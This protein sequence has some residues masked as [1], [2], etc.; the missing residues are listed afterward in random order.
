MAKKGWTQEQ[1][2]T[3][4]KAVH[5]D[6]YDYMPTIFISSREDINYICP[7]HG[8]VTQQAQR[9]ASGAGCL[10]CNHDSVGKRTVM[11]LE[12][13]LAKIPEE[14]KAKH[15]YSRVIYKGKNY[16][17]EIG[18]LVHGTY[19]W[20]N[21]QKHRK[22][23]GCPI[24]ARES[25]KRKTSAI[26]FFKSCRARYGDSFDYTDSVY[27]GSQEYLFYK[28]N[29]CKN[30]VRQLSYSHENR[31]NGCPFCKQS[32]EEREIKQFLTNDLQLE[33]EINNRKLIVE[34]NKFKE[35]DFY[36][37]SEKFAIEHHGTYYHSE[38]GGNKDKHYH[39]NK[40]VKANEIGIRLIQIFEDEWEFKS[41]IC[42]S[43]LRHRLGKTSTTIYAR[44]CQV[45][46]ISVDEKNDFLNINHIQGQDKSRFKIGL[47]YGEELVSVMTFGVPRS[48]KECQWELIRFCVKQNLNVVGGASKLFQYFIRTYSPISIVSYADRRWSDGELYKKLEFKLA[49]IGR[50]Q[51]F[52]L[53]RKNYLR[54]ED[55]R[56]Y[57]K[58]NIKLKFPDADLTKHEDVL[59]IE[60][61]YDRIWD[62][63][64]LTFIW[65]K[66]NPVN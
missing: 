17:I 27:T 18:C 13:Y 63:G 33:V 24:C 45:R 11:T 23:S 49:S 43:L 36:I 4:C 53:N 56:N 2:F 26:I 9:H 7:T 50:P 62:C 64:S 19:F 48:N 32:K 38:I 22:G 5:G 25:P 1:F 6:K 41:D 42:K 35:L 31:G 66:E 16:E 14:H 61:G 65:K 3:K 52:Y 47:F 21:T 34:D 54:R 12:E 37:P 58:E 57:T 59:M 10:K 44:K 39:L 8:L 15:D 30:T 28:C 29:T 46:E 20:Q 51:Y 40:L 55:R 60:Y